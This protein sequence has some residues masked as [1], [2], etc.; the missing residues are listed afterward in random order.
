MDMKLFI[1]NKFSICTFEDIES[2][3]LTRDSGYTRIN[4]KN[5]RNECVY[6][7][8]LKNMDAM[9]LIDEVANCIQ[10]YGAVKRSALVFDVSKFLTYKDKDSDRSIIV[11]DIIEE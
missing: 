9:D 2:T 4:F 10:T 3:S 11:G 5:Q 6:F 7:I 1:K 8:D